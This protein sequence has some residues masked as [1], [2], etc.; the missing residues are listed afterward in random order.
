ML[1]A[2]GLGQGLAVLNALTGISSSAL[3]KKVRINIP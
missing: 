3:V 2:A 1:K